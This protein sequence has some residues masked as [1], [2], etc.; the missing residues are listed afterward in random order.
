MRAGG[1]LS[2][3][4]VTVLMDPGKDAT[5]MQIEVD[6]IMAVSISGLGCRV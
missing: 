3:E 6:E 4:E 2:L 5:L 1:S